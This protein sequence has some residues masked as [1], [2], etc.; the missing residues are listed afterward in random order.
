MGDV[1]AGCRKGNL[2]DGKGDLGQN[3]AQEAGKDNTLYPTD[4]R[5]PD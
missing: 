1:E 4:V 3:S 5:T 2:V